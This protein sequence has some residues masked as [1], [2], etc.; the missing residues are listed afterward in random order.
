MCR[1]G[2]EGFSDEVDDGVLLMLLSGAGASGALQL[3]SS[4]RGVVARLCRTSPAGCGDGSGSDSVAVL[5]SPVAT[6]PTVAESLAASLLGRAVA[7]SAVTVAVAAASAEA[8]ATA[9]LEV[10][11]A[12]AALRL[13]AGV[14]RCRGSSFVAALLCAPLCAA[15]LLS[16][17]IEEP[18]DQFLEVLLRWELRRLASSQVAAVSTTVAVA[19]AALECVLAS[20]GGGRVL[21]AVA[22]HVQVAEGILDQIVEAGLIAQP[23]SFG[24]EYVARCRSAV[25]V[26]RAKLARG[27]SEGS[28]RRECGEGPGEEVEDEASAP[29]RDALES[30]IKSLDE[31]IAGYDKE[32]YTLT[33]PA[34][35]RARGPLPYAHWWVFL[36]GG[37]GYSS[38]GTCS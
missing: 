14:E 4:S 1:S 28:G 20:P 15:L 10:A 29:A 2:W 27:M 12:L 32:G 18:G 16:S 37:Q 36:G 11:G 38:T 34:L 22:A 26:L 6:E 8:S 9:R 25:E 23:R 5:S 31:T 3:A 17:G 30:A 35:A 13:A 7:S 24:Y 21:R 33:C 19:D